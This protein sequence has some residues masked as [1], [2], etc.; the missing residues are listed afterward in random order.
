MIP[1]LVFVLLFNPNNFFIN[2]F[3]LFEMSILLRG[4]KLDKTSR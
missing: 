4:D 3:I 2:L 1:T